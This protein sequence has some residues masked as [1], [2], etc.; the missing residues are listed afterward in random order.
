MQSSENCMQKRE[1]VEGIG[2]IFA[3]C[4]RPLAAEANG[5]CNGLDYQVKNDIQ[6]WKWEKM[7]NN[8]NEIYL[9]FY[10]QMLQIDFSAGSVHSAALIG[11]SLSARVDDL[12]YCL[13][14]LVLNQT[15]RGPVLGL[16]DLLCV[17]RICKTLNYQKNWI[18]HD[19][20]C[21]I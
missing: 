9:S 5:T 4:W 11:S 7:V 19:L 21:N 12:V 14:W 15:K 13:L 8:Q 16:M 2:S 3:A 17:S 20:R 1:V 6:T 18:G 10:F